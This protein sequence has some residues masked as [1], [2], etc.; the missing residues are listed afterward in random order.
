[1]AD[2]RN[3]GRWLF[4]AF[5][6]QLFAFGI[7]QT[8]ARADYAV[9]GDDQSLWL[10]KTEGGTVEIS[11]V[12]GPRFE[13]LETSKPR[14]GVVAGRGIAT[15]GNTLWLV[16]DDGS[17]MWVKPRQQVEMGQATMVI[18]LVRTLPIK[19]NVVD[20][21][22]GNGRLW[23]LIEVDDTEAEKIDLREA[24]PKFEGKQAEAKQEKVEQTGNA[25]ATDTGE[26]ETDK[27]DGE[28]ASANDAEEHGQASGETKPKRY[29]LLVLDDNQWYRVP[30]PAADFSQ[31]NAKSK[32]AI[33]QELRLVSGLSDAELS[34]VAMGPTYVVERNDDGEMVSVTDQELFHVKAY[35]LLQQID[36][37][38]DEEGASAKWEEPTVYLARIVGYD[39]GK[40]ID[41]KIVN[42]Q[43]LLSHLGREEKQ[44]RL[45]ACL[46]PKSYDMV[47]E[48][49]TPAMDVTFEEIDAKDELL[50]VGMPNWLG[51]VQRLAGGDLKLRQ[52]T[53]TGDVI[54]P[55]PLKKQEISIADQA[56]R[57]L[58][59]MATLVA[60]TLM[61][62]LLWRHDASKQPLKLKE[63]ARLADALPRILAGLFDLVPAAILTSFIVKVSPLAMHES[64]PMLT[65]TMTGSVPFF[66]MLGIFFV[67][68]T[69]FEMFGGTTLGKAL[70]G[71]RVTDLSTEKP[72]AGAVVIRN[73]LKLLD[74]M[75]PPLLLLILVSPNRQRIGDIL[76]KTIV[77]VEPEEKDQESESDEEK[78]QAEMKGNEKKHDEKQADE[79]QD[80]STEEKS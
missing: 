74:L 58:V 14:N 68:A 51:V 34:L 17:I 77:I 67:Y 64:H 11:L 78:D 60:A 63:P 39:K 19:P 65:A 4:L 20:A 12:R 54:G 10:V 35:P 7:V 24:W 26:G 32:P 76:A 52:V 33:L 38:E 61:L 15:D 49:L 36:V 25:E 59:T 47:T 56:W 2:K 37:G 9:A 5:I 50:V 66:V 55:T 70:F 8:D 45:R 13:V 71:M 41:F 73:L 42:E 43:L 3:I 29:R 62:V 18:N 31:V 79:S 69:L 27:T 80:E 22:A 23:V 44:A 72:K 46:L 28:K 16:F 1:M 6:L 40:Q 30:M 57:S 48:D 21:A 75:A 53:L